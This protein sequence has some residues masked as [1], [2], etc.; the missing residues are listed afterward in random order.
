MEQVQQLITKHEGFRC[1][2]YRDTRGRRTIG[3]GFNLDDPGAETTCQVHGLDYLTL[4]DGSSMITL[5][6][7]SAVRDDKILA[8][9]FA[10][11][12]TIPNFDGLPDNVQAVVLDMIF[13]MGWPVFSGFHATIAAINA[14]DFRTAASNMKQSAWYGEVP[15]RAQE[16][17]QLMLSAGA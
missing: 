2:V 11:Q 8:A 12:G 16:D 9:K 1:V 13:N 5:K 17:C 7:A 14:G 6:E 4:L 3:I 15:S 10:A